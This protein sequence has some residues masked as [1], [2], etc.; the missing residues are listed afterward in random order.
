MRELTA[1]E[2]C[3]L[4]Q[5]YQIIEEWKK[6]KDL[7]WMYYGNTATFVRVETESEYNDEGGYDD[8]IDNI[9]VTDK[10]RAEIIPNFSLP[11]WT[12]FL[13]TQENNDSVDYQKKYSDETTN[14]DIIHDVME[15]LQVHFWWL[16]PTE[17]KI[18]NLAIA[19]TPLYQH[20]YVEDN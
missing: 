11:A 4:G 2:I 10:D 12:E 19:P 20:V 15:Y 18:Y 3:K 8:Y 1:S 14:N 5:E 9:I 16:L 7:T 17:S 13:Q 6:V